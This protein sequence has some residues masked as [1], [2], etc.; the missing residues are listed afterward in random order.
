M[1]A[2]LGDD[3]TGRGNAGALLEGGAVAKLVQR[4]GDAAEV[5]QHALGALRN[6]VLVGSSP[7]IEALLMS[8]A[9]PPIVAVLTAGDG[10]PSSLDE[11]AM[12][13]LTV[14]CESSDLVVQR[15]SGGPLLGTL[16]TTAL[17]RATGP[18]HS[19]LARLAACKLLHTLSEDN[20]AL[21]SRLAAAPDVHAVVQGALG[22]LDVGEAASAPQVSLAA[23][24]HLTAF[25]SNTGLLSGP[26]AQTAAGAFATLAAAVLP[27]LPLLSGAMEVAAAIDTAAAAQAAHAEAMALPSAAG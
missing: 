13:L 24:C 11:P 22:A 17:A 25:A 8:D 3:E 10:S 15:I 12:E 1:A 5:A 27:T 23:R 7:A 4:V 9:M 2:V 26:S 21:A 6:L 14:L 18:G 20:P 16:L 19:A